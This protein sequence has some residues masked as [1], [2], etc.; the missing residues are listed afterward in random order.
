MV[1]IV[2]VHWGVLAALPLSDTS[3]ARCLGRRT[4]WWNPHSLLDVN[5]PRWLF[6]HHGACLT[7]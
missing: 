5:D 1:E 4:Y 2:S 7:L 6:F 3:R